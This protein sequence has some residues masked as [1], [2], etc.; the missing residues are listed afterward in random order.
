MNQSGHFLKRKEVFREAGEPR[1]GA[2][3]RKSVLELAIQITETIHR[4]EG[5]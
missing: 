4:K 3:F 1:V 5:K 2:K